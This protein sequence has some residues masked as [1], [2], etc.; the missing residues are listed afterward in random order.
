MIN[1]REKTLETWDQ[2]Y[3]ILVQQA[4]ADESDRG[5][6]MAYQEL[7]YL[8][9]WDKGNQT[10]S[11]SG[12]S[13]NHYS[14]NWRFSG[15][16]LGSMA[17]LLGNL[18]VG[19]SSLFVRPAPDFQTPERIKLCNKINASLDP[20]EDQLELLICYGKRS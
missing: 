18:E 15:L 17:Q 5:R 11:S 8:E 4:G 12:S 10:R 13:V 16:V 7:R 14:I 2:V 20:L 6:F 9:C 19:C 3:T 1:V